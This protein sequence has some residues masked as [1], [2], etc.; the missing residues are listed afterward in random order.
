MA[1]IKR[2]STWLVPLIRVVS[3]RDRTARPMPS[4]RETGGFESWL[5][6]TLENRGHPF[7]M[8]CDLLTILGEA[9]D[10]VAYDEYTLINATAHMLDLGAVVLSASESL[11]KARVP[12]YL[13]LSLALWVDD[14][15]LLQKATAII[16]TEADELTRPITALGAALGS[17]VAE[18]ALTTG[19]PLLGH[20]FHQMLLF[21]EARA[22]ARIARLVAL[23]A[24]DLGGQPE[25]SAVM[26]VLGIARGALHHALSACV[27]LTAADGIIEPRERRL[28]EA[29]CSAAH[30]SE[31]ERNMLEAEFDAPQSPAQLG[32]EVSDPAW[33]RAILRL[34]CLA[35]GVDGEVAP[36]EEI[37]LKTLAEA[38]GATPD[39]LSMY[40]V[41]ALVHLQQHARLDDAFKLTGQLGQLRAR[42]AARIDEA[43]RDNSTRL[44]AELKQTSEL[45]QLLAKASAEPLTAEERARARAQL[46]DLARAIPSLA[47][48]AAPGGALLL[49]LL[50][51]HLP[52]KI[53]PSSFSDEETLS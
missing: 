30:L 39:E 53:L 3:Q 27:A 24:E 13:L 12:H 9:V 2:S 38:F 6:I 44:W 52:F 17:A 32:E 31:E 28:V 19:H 42:L 20:P 48:F 8:P 50:V 33:R 7:G 1:H 35:A 21:S 23:S 34:L 29:L 22:F 16:E 26:R 43:I 10:G 36:P 46:L 4:L 47:I 11:V 15:E 25:P 18:R 40:E 37:F 45:G 14:E 51:K 49:P 41:E 5:E